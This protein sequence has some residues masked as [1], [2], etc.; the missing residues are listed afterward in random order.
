MARILEIGVTIEEIESRRERVKKTKRFELTDRIPVIPAIAHRF[1]VPQVGVRFKDYYSNPETMLHTQILAQKWLMEHIRTDAYDI[2]GAW[3][4]AWTDF[5][6]TFEAGSLGCEI[7]FPADDIPWVGRGWVEDDSDL[8][9]LEGMD[10]VHSG[11][12]AKQLAYRRAMI[13]I[14]ENYPVRFQ[15]GPIFYPGLN[16]SL[17]HTSDG[18]FGIAG[19][20]MGQQE[21]FTAVSER[22]DFV[23]ELLEIITAKLIAYLD[24]CWEEES[25]PHPKDFAWTDDLAVSLSA[26]V[27][28]AIV[29][30]S[31]SKLRN[32]FDGYVS[33]HMCGQTDHL[34]TTFVDDLRINEFQ[35]FG[36]QVDLDHI[37]SV[38]GGRV[39]LVG[40]VNPMLIHSGTPDDVRRATKNVI[41]KLAPKRGLIIQ[42]GSNIPPGSPI[43]NINAMMEAAERYGRYR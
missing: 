8:H 13:D 10:F 32:H 40:N 29:L 1:L 26:D 2:T 43:E 6:N 38:M 9:T 27:Y 31:E 34:L 15:G 16:P 19:D 25:L 5:Q 42:D 24:F 23:R 4:G 33:L 37:G 20:L 21:L 12:N 3:T 30:P 35:G 11:I 7:I 41:E 14:A 36:Y 17:T 39:V 22:P 18:P 28:R